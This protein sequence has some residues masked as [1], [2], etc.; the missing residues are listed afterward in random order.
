[1]TATI[2][3]LRRGPLA[4]FARLL[5]VRNYCKICVR[6]KLVYEGDVM[7]SRRSVCYFSHK[8][9]EDIHIQRPNRQK[10]WL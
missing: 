1:M 6:T 8:E 5:T 7:M 2:E 10:L 3:A 9:Q 4:M